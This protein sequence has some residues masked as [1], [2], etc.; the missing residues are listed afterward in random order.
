MKKLIS[1]IADMRRRPALAWTLFFYAPVIAIAIV[2][3]LGVQNYG[4][5]LE[6]ELAD[7]QR[8]GGVVGSINAFG[9]QITK[10]ILLIEKNLREKKSADASVYEL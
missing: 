1:F 7:S 6:A 4:S 9:E 8:T 2:S 3:I 10:S 5:R